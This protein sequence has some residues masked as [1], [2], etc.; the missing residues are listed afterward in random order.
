LIRRE[1]TNRKRYPD[2]WVEILNNECEDVDLTG[3]TL[4]DTSLAGGLTP[5]PVT[6]SM[7][8]KAGERAVL[9]PFNSVPPSPIPSGTRI[10]KVGNSDR[11]GSGFNNDNDTIFIYDAAGSIIDRIRYDCDDSDN[12]PIQNC[13]TDDESL[14]VE[15]SSIA[16]TSATDPTSF[17]LQT[18]SPGG[19]SIADTRNCNPSSS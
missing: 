19:G 17:E 5:F 9:I 7:V 6:E 14:V 18:P 10:F 8:L 1:P 12:T 13:G 16:R 3:W 15:G 11:L 4:G 2:E